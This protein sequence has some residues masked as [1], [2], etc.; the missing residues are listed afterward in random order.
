MEDTVQQQIR[1]SLLQM[2]LDNAVTIEDYEECQQ[3]LELKLS[4]ES[5]NQL[6]VNMAEAK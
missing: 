2:A 5:Q 3:L 4:E 6:A 1:L